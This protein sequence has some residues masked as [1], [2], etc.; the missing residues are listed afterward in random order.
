MR[1]EHDA[2]DRARCTGATPILRVADLEA[3]LRWYVARLAFR[4]DWQTPGVIASVSRDA[5][6]LMLAQADQGL[7]GAWAYIGVTDARRLHD[8]LVAL[9]ATIR[10][11][12]TNYPWALETHV[13]DP[14][15]NV[16]RFGSDPIPGA[17]YGDWLDMRGTWWTPGEAGRWRRR[18]AH[19][20]GA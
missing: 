7:P 14:D 10:L 15:G 11:A 17:P 1:S 6:H 8:E 4:L 20:T 13:Q 18:D 12:P 16:L 9:G 3:S 19:G 2:H 5:A